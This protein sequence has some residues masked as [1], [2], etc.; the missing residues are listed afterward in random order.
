MCAKI[1]SEYAI[2]LCREIAAIVDDVLGDS[3]KEKEV[4]EWS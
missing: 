4:R 1:H 2:H 3:Q